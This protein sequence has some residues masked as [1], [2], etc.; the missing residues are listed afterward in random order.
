MPALF[1]FDIKLQH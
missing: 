1:E